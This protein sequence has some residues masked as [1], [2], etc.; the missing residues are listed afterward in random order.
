[1][2][3]ALLP[4]SRQVHLA[5]VWLSGLIDRPSQIDDKTPADNVE[6]FFVNGVRE[7]LLNNLRLGE[8]IDVLS[9]VSGYVGERLGQP[10][11]FAALIADPTATGELQIAQG[12]QAFARVAASALRRFGGQYADL[13]QRLEVSVYGQAI[14]TAAPASEIKVERGAEGKP[15]QAKARRGRRDHPGVVGGDQRA[16]GGRHS[17]RSKARW[18]MCC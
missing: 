8:A 5:E 2:Q 9:T 4:E 11:D 7:L 16:C 18:T 3:R 6:Y 14:S 1:M 12:Y 13:A 10:L 17:H 15:P